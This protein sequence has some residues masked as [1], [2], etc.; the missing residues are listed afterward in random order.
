VREHS[1]QQGDGSW[2]ALAVGEQ[3]LAVDHRA[4]FTVEELWAGTAAGIQ[5]VLDVLTGRGL[6][7]TP[8]FALL[9]WSGD[10]GLRAIVRG[11]VRL[12]VTVA[13]IEDV[14]DGTGVST[15]TEKAYAAGAKYD[16]H[17]GEPTEGDMLPL[18]SGAASASRV[19][20]AAITASVP[21]AAPSFE[22]PA[23]APVETPAALAAA[24]EATVVA[25]AITPLP[26]ATMQDVSDS[27]EPESSGE[28]T[29]AAGIPATAGDHDGMTVMAS[30]LRRLRAERQSGSAASA[31][32]APAQATLQLELSNG[33]VEPLDTVVIVGRSPSASKVSGGALPRLV[34]LPGDKDISRNHA[35][36][37]VEGGTVVVTDL[38]SRNGTQVIMPGRAPQQLRQGEPTS[39]IVGSV[40]D[41]GGGVTLTVRE[42]K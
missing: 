8:S 41:L 1:Y 40:I 38:H 27:H 34:S 35:Q 20:S 25:G 30:D 24:D 12:V 6:S 3:V 22:V 13:G 16:L 4:G 31:P 14:L 26:E 9:S 21:A 23:A 17:L 36:F 37:A 39:V 18:I 7:A 29:P 2:L 33:T 10:G 11:P 42:G 32:P 28:P 15:W 5:D 19:A